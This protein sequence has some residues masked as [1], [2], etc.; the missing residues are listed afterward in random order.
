MEEVWALLSELAGRDIKLA[1]E[2]GKLNCYAP[3]GALT[4]ALADGITRHKPAIIDIL[5]NGG[6]APSA[7]SDEF[8]LSVGENSHYILQKLNPERSHAVPICVKIGAAVDAGLLAE[9]WDRVIDRFPLLKTRVVEHEGRLSHRLDEACRSR[10]Q[11]ETLALHGDAELVAHFQAKVLEPFD[12]QTGPL[13]RITLF[14]WGNGRT[15]LFILIHHLIFDGFST[16][17]LLRALFGAYR[18]AAAGRTRPAARDASGFEPFVAWESQMLASAEGAQHAAFWQQQLQGE[19]PRFKLLPDAPQPLPADYKAEIVVDVLPDDVSRWLREFARQQSLQHSALFLSLFQLLLHK[20]SSQKDIVVVMPVI[21]RPDSR[22]TDEIGYFFNIVPIRGR[23]DAPQTL[24]DFL[25]GTQMTLLDAVFHSAY[26]FPLMMNR[27]KVEGNTEFKLFYAYQEF[28]NLDDGEFRAV[29]DEFGLAPVSGFRQ[30]AEGDFDIALEV[31]D[32]GDAFRLHLQGNPECCPNEVLR[33]M[34]A[35]LRVLIDGIAQDPQRLLAQYPI[36]T[37]QD[38]ARIAGWNATDAPF[39]RE[40]CIHDFF[41]DQVAAGPERPATSDAER[42][43]NYAELEHET[44][45]LALH[46]QSLGVEPDTIV[47]LCVNRSVDMMIGIQGIVR[48]GGA[49]MPIDPDYPDDRVSYMLEDSAARVILT[50]SRFRDRLQALAGEGATI[51]TLD[52]QWP[53]LRGETARR[54]AQGLALRREV[55]PG[56]VAYVI[57]TSGSTGKPKGVLVEHRALVNRIHWMQ[58]SYGLDSRD[59]VV[60]KTPY[61]FDVSVWEFF[62]PPMTGASLAFAEPNGHSDVQ[63]LEGLINGVGVTTLHYVPSMLHAFL[64]N[65]KGQCPGVRLIFCSGEALDRTSV[66]RYR[67]V[68]PNAALH[69]LYGPTEAAIDVTFYD[70][71]RIAYPFVPIGA[72]ID[73]TQIHIVD[74]ANNPQPVGVP[75]ELHIAGVNLARGYLNRPELTR[76]RF[77]ANPFD[78]GTRMYRTGDLARWLDDGNIQYLG[79]I[80][81]QVK[82]GGVRIETGEIEAHL[83]RHPAISE[84]VVIA[85]GPDGYKQLIAFYRTHDSTRDD[86]V[87]LAHKDLRAHLL[88]TLPEYM[89]PAAFVSVASIPV[90]SNGKADRKALER[91]DVGLESSEEYI[92]PRSDTERAL[93]EIWAHV[94]KEKGFVLE[95]ARIGVNDNFFELGGNSLLATQL[96]YRIRAQLG[97]DLPVRALFD[98]VTIG[99]LAE[100]VESLRAPSAKAAAQGLVVTIQAGGERTPVFVLP[101]VGGN[102]LGLRELS[103]ALGPQQPFHALQAIGLDGTEP[104]P[105]SVE[106]T[107]AANLAAIRAIQPQGPYR[108]V[109]HSYGGVVAYEMTRQLLEQGETVEYLALLDAV[110]PAVLN[111]QP[112]ADEFEDM[113]Q[114]CLEMAGQGRA[115]FDYSAAQLRAMTTEQR[116]AVFAEQGFVMDRE[117]YEG[118]YHLFQANRRC[119]RTYRPRALP[120]PVDVLLFRAM[121]VASAAAAGPTD[122]GWKALVDDTLQAH[123][124]DADHYSL[125]RGA[126]AQAVADVLQLRD[127]ELT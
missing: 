51:I 74:E 34:L 7:R 122:Y 109:G 81:A 73:N 6:A 97:V 85:R 56:N 13:S 78:P 47:A 46:L 5:Q 127:V 90:T 30:E 125:L 75:G 45:L 24:P 95:Q 94:F 88:E 108:L 57:Y 23:F 1:V 26:P 105:D 31:F 69:N 100:L 50:E 28:A 53:A 15:G 9:A 68:F 33:G 14:D 119:Y 8:A 91:I 86:V 120:K 38:R 37:G 66:D 62:W 93:A 10:L 59:V 79:R 49:Y 67:R 52:R 35:H 43:L 110:T 96:L 58:K 115:S 124:I 19:L 83:N 39:P 60:Q 103:R 22:F 112:A 29:R 27:Q 16:G 113:R 18:D 55:G 36:A 76:E 32:D 2:D 111:A 44:G 70:C 77:V 118:L 3:K 4:K 123:T 64:D 63:Y 54:K 61:C 102:V 101:G 40:R 11:R 126:A 107:A 80:D 106:A 84:S 21:V 20:Y 89:I 72:P 98:Q 12:L 87:R 116:L 121:S 25:R 82:I 17:I 92:A 71:T 41:L 114:L 99:Q 48:A 42:R 104:P 117:G 65:A